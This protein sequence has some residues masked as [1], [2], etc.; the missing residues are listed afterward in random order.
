MMEAIKAWE[1][2]HDAIAARERTT[3]ALNALEESTKRLGIQSTFFKTL[4]YPERSQELVLELQDVHQAFIAELNVLEKG[5]PMAD[6]PLDKVR[7]ALACMFSFCTFTVSSVV[8]RVKDLG[9]LL[10]RL[11]SGLTEPNTE[12]A[13]LLLKSIRNKTRKLKRLAFELDDAREDARGARNC[14]NRKC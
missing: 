6:A 14:S 2:R 12:N 13:E 1:A 4:T 3:A 11:R 8:S 10:S 9:H 5:D 7:R